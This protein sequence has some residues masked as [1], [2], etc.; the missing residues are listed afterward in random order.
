MTSSDAIDA[1]RLTLALNDL[2]LPAIKT[3][4]PDFAARADKEG[5]PAARFLAALAE[6]EMAER[7]SRRIQRHLDEAR[8]PPGKTLD[9]FDFEAV[10]MISKAQ[11]MALAAGDSWLEKTDVAK[12]SLLKFRPIVIVLPASS[13][14]MA[15]PLTP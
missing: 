6:H 3:I 1:G 8:L 15:A 13:P 5:W 12:N 7:A 4:W 10:P 9:S 2:R 14:L 11:V